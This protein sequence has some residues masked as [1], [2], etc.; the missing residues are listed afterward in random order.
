MFLKTA[1]IAEEVKSDPRD[2]EIMLQRSNTIFRIPPLNR[3]INRARKLTGEKDGT[4]AEPSNIIQDNFHLT[5][6]RF[7]FRYRKAQPRSKSHGISRTIDRRT[8][9]VIEARIV[10]NEGFTADFWKI[11]SNRAACCLV[12]SPSLFLSPPRPILT[13]S[14][15]PPRAPTRGAA[16]RWNRPAAKRECI[17]RLLSFPPISYRKE[18]E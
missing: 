11:D 4:Q 8:N 18:K 12:S 1:Y 10:V 7:D 17:S 5:R 15:S 14:L 6:P 16:Q 3:T 2:L 13:L 9:S